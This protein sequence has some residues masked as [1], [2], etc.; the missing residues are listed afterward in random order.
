M[1]G[2][3][4]EF[5]QFLRVEKNASQYTIDNYLSDLKQFYNFLIKETVTAYKDV[6]HQ[7]IRLFLTELYEKDL[8]RRTVSRKLSSLRI[9]FNFLEKDEVIQTNPFN[10][11]TLPKI[12]KRIPEFFYKEELEKLF[13]VEDLKSPLSERNQAI[14][15]VLYGTGIRVSE[16]IGLKV[17]DIDFTVGTILVTGKGNKQR[18]VPFGVYASEALQRYMENGRTELQL[19]GDQETDVLFLNRLGKPLTT[20]GVRH[21][22]NEMIKK[23]ALTSAIHPHKLRHTFA[24][25]LLNEGADMRSVQEMLGHENLSSTQIYTHVTKDYLQKIYKNAHPRA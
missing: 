6:N 17:Q 18:Y 1:Q 23:A 5:V 25:H 4:N 22:L 11:V 13:Q 14:I 7:V 19:K 24:T 3:I 2:K 20:R 10:Q 9:F 15:E 12:T 21:I 16:L 8:S